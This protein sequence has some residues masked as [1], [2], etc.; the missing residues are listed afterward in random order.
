MPERN[1]PIQFFAHREQDELRTEGG[2]G[3]KEP[4][5]L[6]PE[7]LL[8]KKSEQLNS[9]LVKF[10]TAVL[11]REKKQSII[12]FVFKVC[13]LDNATAKY[14]RN[15]VAKILDT[16]KVRSNI[17]GLLN[18]EELLVRISTSHELEEI[19]NQIK[20]YDYNKYGISCL[21]KITNFNPF[22][23]LVTDKPESYKVRLLNFQDYEDNQAIERLFENSLQRHNLSYKKTRYTESFPIYNILGRHTIILDA[24][25]QSEVF[26]ALF[27]IEPMPRYSLT[28]DSE[29]FQ[30]TLPILRPKPG[31]EYAT[32]GILDSGIARIPHLEPWLESKRWAVYPDD[33]IKP[34][35]GTFI[36]G[37]ALYGDELEKVSW[38][39][40]KGVRLFDATI[41]PDT[42][43]ETIQE[44]E[45]I[46]NIKEVIKA[47]HEKV[48]IWNLSIS[49]S[50][51]ISENS[52]SDLAVSLDDIQETY[53]V[54]IC[55]SAG[56]CDN[57]ISGRPRGKLHMG[58]DSVL[59]LVIGSIAHEKGTYDFADVDNPSP[60][61]R[62]GPGPE[63]IIKPELVHYGGN[64]GVKP[65]GTV[66][67]TGVKSLS[68]DGNIAQAVGTSFSTPRIAGLAAGLYQEINQEFD[69]L[70]I[71]CMVVHSA[72]YPDNL[73]IP[74]AERT[75]YVGYGKPPAIPDILYNNPHE[76]T[77]IL[78]ETLA[79][80]KFLDIVDF[81]MPSCLINNGFYNGQIIVTLAYSPILEQSQGSE[82]CQSN[83]EVYFGT[84]DHL[85]ERDT[86]RP[87]ILN[88][89][90]R[91]NPKNIFKYE[92]Y[93]KEKM[94]TGIGAFSQQ[95]R[96]LIQ[97][98]DKYYPVKKYAVDLSEMTDTN[99]R[100][101]VTANK[102]WNLK[103]SGLYRSFSEQQAVHSRQLSQDFCLLITIK[104]PT[105]TLNVYDETI[106]KLEAY[107]FWHSSI[108]LYSQVNIKN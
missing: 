57:F 83:I 69:P 3:G 105:E 34:S 28:L 22:V 36:A 42:S 81:P 55:K 16:H 40:H 78:R 8:A 68:V 23:S 73:V 6:L 54:L 35:H 102:K 90:G 104:D 99:K 5:W 20:E 77:L 58:A 107:N 108:N 11:E 46:Q 31:E 49:R 12:P 4:K 85:K 76:I 64:A 103:L 89:V 26:E 88:P 17:I 15:H 52:F 92:L 82:Y 61:T 1:F 98:A 41:F 2:G 94:K 10:K 39:G 53:N 75:K 47:N 65:D 70:L 48:K 51:P 106:Q 13:L 45:L 79:K 95:E 30:D 7:T 96:L 60:F 91:E 56:N 18:E 38:M 93:S 33:K 27:S 100:K 25:K 62:I 97:Y 87:T 32:V 37:I 59:S 74:N 63:F 24:F 67:K 29:A 50:D 86:K 9:E 66:T 71:K 43:K 21:D 101:Y 14:K 84:Y 19:S 72:K 80:G 44:D